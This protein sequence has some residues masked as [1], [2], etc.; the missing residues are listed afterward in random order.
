VSEPKPYEISKWIVW[1]AY[2]KVKANRGAAGVDG[3]SI[4]EF[5]GDLKG[6]LYKLWNRMSSGSYFPPPVRAVD[7]PKKGRGR[8]DPRRAHGPGIGPVRSGRA[9]FRTRWLLLIRSIRCLASGWRLCSRRA[10]RGRS[11][12]WCVRAVRL[13]G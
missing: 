10:A 7:I 1:E 4:A 5:E 11:G 12:W 8:E 2:E 6:N 13:G 9:R 3:E